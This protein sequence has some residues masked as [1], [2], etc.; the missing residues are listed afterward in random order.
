MR[1]D[2]NDLNV[3]YQTGFQELR[4]ES[5]ITN[6]IVRKIKIQDREITKNVSAN[7]RSQQLQMRYLS[8]SLMDMQNLT[9]VLSFRV[10]DQQKQTIAEIQHLTNTIDATTTK[11]NASLS[12][13]ATSHG[14]N[15][16]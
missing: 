11:F 7:L 1:D 16:L 15:K 6:E 9:N 5:Q 3:T 10:D 2:L 8:L 4:L 12:H 14:M 13:I